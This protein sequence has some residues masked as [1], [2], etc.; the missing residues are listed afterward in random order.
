MPVG[1]RWALVRAGETVRTQEQNAAKGYGKLKGISY[2]RETALDTRNCKRRFPYFQGQRILESGDGSYQNGRRNWQSGHL[3]QCRFRDSNSVYA[4]DSYP[5]NVQTYGCCVNG[6]GTPI[7]LNLPTYFGTNTALF[8][9]IYC[10]RI[11]ISKLIFKYFCRCVKDSYFIF[12]FVY[13][14]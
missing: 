5:K 1:A 7:N 11:N 14:V 2:Q 9:L 12:V 6:C 4:C 3:N 10:N 8:T 13:A